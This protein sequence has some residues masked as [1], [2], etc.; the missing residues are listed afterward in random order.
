[1]ERRIADLKEG[2]RRRQTDGQM[3]R[4]EERVSKTLAMWHG[5]AKSREQALENEE[6]RKL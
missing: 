5:S 6:L 3:R 1:M 2:I 4:E